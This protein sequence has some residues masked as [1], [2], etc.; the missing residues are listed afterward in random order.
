YLQELKGSEE[1][2]FAVYKES[3]ERWRKEGLNT[4]EVIKLNQQA[5]QIVLQAYKSLSANK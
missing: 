5:D 2:I 3:I 4:P 1:S